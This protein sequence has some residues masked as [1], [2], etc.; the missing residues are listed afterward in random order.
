MAM[1]NVDF[2]YEYKGDYVGVFYD[3]RVISIHEDSCSE[4]RALRE[5]KRELRGVDHI[6]MDSIF[7]S[8]ISE[9]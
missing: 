1:F 4:G 7:I 8:D 2:G 5:I 9:Y 3:S 6:D